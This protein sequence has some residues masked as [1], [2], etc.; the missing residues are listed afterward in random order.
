MFENGI[1]VYVKT[2]TDNQIIAIGSDVFIKDLSGWVLIDEGIGDKFAHAQTQ[3]LDKEII[4][5]NGNPNFELDGTTV[6]KRKSI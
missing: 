5:E 2:N 1:K 3:Y 4:D 6:K